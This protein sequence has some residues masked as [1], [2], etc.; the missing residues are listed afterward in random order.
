M[1]S[2]LRVNYGLLC[3]ICGRLVVATSSQVLQTQAIAGTWVRLAIRS[4][5]TWQP[6]MAHFL[7]W[8]MAGAGIYSSSALFC[9]RIRPQVPPRNHINY[10]GADPRFECASTRLALVSSLSVLPSRPYSRILEEETL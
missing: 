9:G 1:K 8:S 4:R 7:A 3:N 5:N 6:R 10:V 2:P